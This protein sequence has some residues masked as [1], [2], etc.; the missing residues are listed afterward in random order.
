[1]QGACGLIGLRS[2]AIR[3]G[4]RQGR[5]PLLHAVG[6]RSG[7]ARGG[8]RSAIARKGRAPAP[9]R[10]WHAAGTRSAIARGRD[11]LPRDPAWHVS[12]AYFRFLPASWRTVGFRPFLASLECHPGSRGSAS[13]PPIMA[14]HVLFRRVRVRLG[15]SN[16]LLI[17][18]VL[19][20]CRRPILIATIYLLFRGQDTSVPS[21]ICETVHQDE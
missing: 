21:R 4:T 16:V 9:I 20:P 3:G 8:M 11:A 7:V 12:E 14:D 18:I 13:L 19:A 10:R 17:V 1:M 2:R 5:D 6:T 15:T